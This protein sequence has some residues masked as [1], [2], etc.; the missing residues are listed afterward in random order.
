[1]DKSRQ[2]KSD[3]VDPRGLLAGNGS[4]CRSRPTADV[5]FRL[6][7]ELQLQPELFGLE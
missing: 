5:R 3:I 7:L 6:E 2:W 4:I 1:M